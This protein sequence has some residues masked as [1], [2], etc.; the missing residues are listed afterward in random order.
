[1]P[2]T[3]IIH[4]FFSEDRQICGLTLQPDGGN[5]ARASPNTVWNYRDSASMTPDGVAK[6]VRDPHHAISNLTARGFYLARVTAQIIP[7]PRRSGQS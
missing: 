7:F 4:V 6:F 5:L 1:M 2:Q 3:P